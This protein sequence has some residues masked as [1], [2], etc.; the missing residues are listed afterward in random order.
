MSR[1][2]CTEAA[3]YLQPG[4]EHSLLFLAW[5]KARITQHPPEHGYVTLRTVIR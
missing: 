3:A 2:L 4:A 1:T 5:Q